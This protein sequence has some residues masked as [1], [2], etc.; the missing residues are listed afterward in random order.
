MPA[1]WLRER[2]QPV[3][4]VTLSAEKHLAKDWRCSSELWGGDPGF[5]AKFELGSAYDV[6]SLHLPSAAMSS[7]LARLRP[8]ASLAFSLGGIFMSPSSPISTITAA[9]RDLTKTKYVLRT[10]RDTAS[11]QR[12]V[13]TPLVFVSASALD[14]ESTKG[15]A[16]V[17]YLC[18]I[19]LTLFAGG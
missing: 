10:P 5:N 7:L 9:T 4:H 13:P 3:S 18:L 8:H 2:F 15:C 14:E 19:V 6:I 1:T 16:S 11:L 17:M 12:E